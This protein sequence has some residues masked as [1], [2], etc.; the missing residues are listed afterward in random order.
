[1]DGSLGVLI[2]KTFPYKGVKSWAAYKAWNKEV[3]SEGRLVNP[4]M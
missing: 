2:L 3:L 4:K 1:M